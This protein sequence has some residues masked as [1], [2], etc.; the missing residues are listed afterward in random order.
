MIPI[1]EAVVGGVLLSALSTSIGLAIGKGSKLSKEDFH[2][3]CTERQSACTQNMCSELKHIKE[4]QNEMRS[5]I[6]ELLK[7]VN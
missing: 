7:R 3:I 6:K 1:A 4:E 5:D 2:R